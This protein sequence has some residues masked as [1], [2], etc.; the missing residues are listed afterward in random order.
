MREQLD[1]FFRE[2]GYERIPSNLPEFSVYYRIE[3]SHVNA[4]QLIDYKEDLYLTEEQYTHIS[5]KVTEL[6]RQKGMTEIHMLSL[7]VSEDSAKARALCGSDR[8]CWILDTS[9]QRLLIYENK[10]PDFYGLRGTL[11]KWIADGCREKDAGDCA[12]AQREFYGEDIRDSQRAGADR[13]TFRK[14]W[15]KRKIIWKHMP[16]VTVILIAINVI[17]YLMCTFWGELLYNKGALDAERI[18]GHGEYYRIMTA[19]FLHSG[20]THLFNNMLMLYFFGDM[21]E[22]RLGRWRFAVLY[23]LSGLGGSLC[24]LHYM[25]LSD[26][27]YVSIGASGAVFGIEGALLAL[28][29]LNRGR[30]KTVTFGRLAFMIVYSLYIGF[31]STDI[32]NYA[33]IG[34]VIIGFLM[35][36]ILH[37]TKRKAEST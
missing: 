31:G 23:V 26:S 37:F 27:P 8:F 21:V 4:V 20:P 32:D 7:I 29:V 24:S 28:V 25:L 3:Q 16:Q 30:L 2:M 6:F 33:H 5:G 34:G 13:R 18:I 19:W 15:K 35:C 36:F 17:V 12:G 22:K 11:E 10:T 1:L 14:A 9:I